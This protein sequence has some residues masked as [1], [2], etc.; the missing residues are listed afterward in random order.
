MTF[1]KTDRIKHVYICSKCKEVTHASF[2]D[3]EIAKSQ[4][5]IE[6][7]CDL[8]TERGSGWHLSRIISCEVR[9]GQYIPHRGGCYTDFPTHIRAKNAC[10][11]IKTSSKCFVYSILAS[12][13]SMRN[14]N[15]LESYDKFLRLYNFS[16]CLDVVELTQISKFSRENDIS[17]NVYSFSG[18]DL[19]P[20][21]IDTER[22]SKHVNLLLHNK[23]HFFIKNVNRLASS[24]SKLQRF[25]C[26]NCLC[27]FRDSEAL[28]KHENFCNRPQQLYFGLQ[29]RM[30]CDAISQRNQFPL[31]NR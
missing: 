7:I 30:S 21:Q 13:H 6:T 18:L 9:V 4:S 24:G 29:Q 14:P 26:Y 8:F 31:S 11:N 3:S 22:K 17:I 12:L 19:L 5:E 23:H 10:I 28:A 15:R 2:I 25:F 16:D 20:I 1:L 27:G